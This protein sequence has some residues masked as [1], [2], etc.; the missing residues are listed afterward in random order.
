MVDNYCVNSFVTF[1]TA[2]F[3]RF[4]S[5]V[6]RFWRACAHV[7]WRD[8]VCQ[9]EHRPCYRVRNYVTGVNLLVI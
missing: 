7:H 4:F 3:F 1:S 9:N 5:G 2:V 6:A 8:P